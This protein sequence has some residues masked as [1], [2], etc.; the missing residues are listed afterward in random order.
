MKTVVF[1]YIYINYK[2]NANTKRVSNIHKN[3]LNINTWNY[4]AGHSCA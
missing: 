1:R 3:I 2:F 4:N